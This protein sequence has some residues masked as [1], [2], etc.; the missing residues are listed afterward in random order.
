LRSGSSQ[1]N[2]TASKRTNAVCNGVLKPR[3]LDLT[4][5]TNP[6]TVVLTIGNNTA[7]TGVTAQFQ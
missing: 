2:R 7:T 3:A 6:V 4:G 5:L 1:E